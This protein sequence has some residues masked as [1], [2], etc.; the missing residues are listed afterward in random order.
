[1][2][3]FIDSKL[4]R[5]RFRVRRLAAW[6]CLAIL[7]FSH[8]RCLAQQSNAADLAEHQQWEQLTESIRN[9]TAKPNTKQPDGT[10]AL[11]WSAFHGNSDAVTT[12]LKSGADT[13]SL[14][15]YDVSPLSIACE[16]GH[17]KV[18]SLLIDADA[19]LEQR[20]LGRER[21]LMLAA[22]N[23]NATIVEKLI[24][25]GAD[26]NAREVKGQNALM[27]AA[28]EGNLETVKKLIEAGA[29]TT[30]KLKSGFNPLMFAARNGRSSTVQFLAHNGFDIESTLNPPKTSGRHPRKGMS[31]LM[32]AIESGHLELA[33]KIIEWGGDPNDQRSGF[34]PLHALITVRRSNR[35]DDVAS[36]PPPRITGK[37]DSLE[38]VR[39]IVKA[40]ADINLQLEKGKTGQAKLS[41]RGATPFLLASANADL[42]LMKLLLELGADPELTNADDCNALMAAA[43]VGAIAVDE[44]PGSEEEV[45][46]AI[47]MLHGLGMDPDHVDKNRET[48]M[49]GA[50]YRAYP[51]AIATL[52]KIGATPKVWNQQNK[53]S[54]TPY[55]IAD[56]K[57]PGSVKP[58][59]ETKAALDLVV[60]ASQ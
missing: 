29:D 24:D 38:F 55:D 53:H 16:L 37:I 12:L 1:M 36:D 45:C 6:S 35:G 8:S 14:N 7:C 39:Q 10:T 26:L 28:A 32:L 51:N 41:R 49:H 40:G 58:S 54:W 44:Y 17:A 2:T 20:R 43:G 22:R 30:H 15:Q 56:G 9:K 18:A 5:V 25:A 50:A 3:G 33:L 48:A 42:E 23:G 19:D 59:P 52:A 46:A 4:N 47:K 31:P 13:N 57:R 11:H 21:P 34:A 60:Q 27:W